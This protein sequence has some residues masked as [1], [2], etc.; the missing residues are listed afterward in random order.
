MDLTVPPPAIRPTVVPSPHADL[1]EVAVVALDAAATEAWIRNGGAELVQASR[2]DWLLAVVEH[3]TTL[4]ELARG[5][6]ATALASLQHRGS[7]PLLIVTYPNL[8]EAATRCGEL[9][10]AVATT[11][12][13]AARIAPHVSGFGPGLLARCRALVDEGPGAEPSY[14]EAIAHLDTCTF[15][16]ARTRLVYGEWLRRAKRRADAREQLRAA[17][18]VFTALG[19]RTLAARAQVELAAAGESTPRREVA[20]ITGLTPQEMHIARLAADGWTNAEIAGVL[21]LSTSTVDYHLRKVFRKLGVTSRR[22]LRTVLRIGSDG[23][24]HPPAA[25]CSA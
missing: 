19:A 6:Y 12:L 3:A 16:S 17:D 25:L 20:P 18:E 14:R 24:A 22:K 7:G 4:L 21:F 15:E 2:S 23:L 9:H 10:T 8:V 13:L 1:A 5:H 11:E